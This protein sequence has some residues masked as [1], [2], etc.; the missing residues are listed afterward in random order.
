MEKI[1]NDA[2]ASAEWKKQCEGMMKQMRD[3]KLRD[4]KNHKEVIIIVIK[5]RVWY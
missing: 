5:L 4:E 2:K 1:R 3:D